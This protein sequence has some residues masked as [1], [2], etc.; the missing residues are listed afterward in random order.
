M[1]LKKLYVFILLQLFES[2]TTLYK[3]KGSKTAKSNI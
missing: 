2:Y 1:V 3:C